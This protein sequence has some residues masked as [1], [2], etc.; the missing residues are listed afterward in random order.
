M[1]RIVVACIGVPK[2]SGAEAAEDIAEEFAKH[3]TWHENVSCTWDGT[4]LVLSA[5]NDVD[6]TG[7][8]LLDEFSDCVCAYVPGGGDISVR[9]ISVKET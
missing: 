3:R 8:A 1:Y 4:R 5:E 9:V 2:E 6:S 7:D